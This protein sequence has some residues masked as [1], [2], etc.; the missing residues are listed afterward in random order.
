MNRLLLVED[1]PLFRKGLAKMITGSTT[2]WSV[3]GEAENGQ[4]AE[5]LIAELLPDLVITDIRMPLLNGLELLKR[6][7]SRFPDIEFIVITGFQDFNMLRL[8]F[9]MVHSICLSSPAVN[10]MYMTR[11]I[12]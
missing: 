8:H 12:K 4:E 1:E 9:V 7:K 11:W 10:R 5:S 6:V 3:C 2:N